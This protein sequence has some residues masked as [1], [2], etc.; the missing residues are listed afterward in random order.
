MKSIKAILA[1]SVFVIIVIL[2]LQL[3]YIFIAVAYNALA[4]DYPFLHDIAGYFRYII[5]IPVFVAVMFVG[6]Y[7]T[8][9]VAA[10]ESNTKVL[11]LCMAVGLITAGGMIYPTLETADITTTGIVIFILSLLAT[12]AGGW[13]WQKDNVMI[14]T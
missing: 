3:L 12:T 13:Y 4:S 8:A 9:N 1:G 5:G 14:Q 10:M 6:G 11:L 7:I 2:I